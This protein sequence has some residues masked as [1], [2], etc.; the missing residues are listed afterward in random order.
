ML[1]MFVGLA[2]VGLGLWAV[3][4]SHSGPEWGYWTIAGTGASVVLY[5]GVYR[6]E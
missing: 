1:I 6:P 2:M 3:W 4:S 5:S